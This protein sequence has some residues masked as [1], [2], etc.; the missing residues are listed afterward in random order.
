MATKNDP[1]AECIRQ[2]LDY[3]PK[4]GIFVWKRRSPN[5][6]KDG[7]HS[8]E[9]KCAVW[10]TKFAGK[11]AGTINNKGYGSIVIRGIAMAAHRLA[12]LYVNDIYPNDQID[13]IDGNRSNNKI[14]NLRE[15]VNG[16]NRN[17]AKLQK[18]NT[19]GDKNVHYCKSAKKWL[20]RFNINE[21]K[22]TVFRSRD[23]ELSALVAS[24]WRDYL[25]GEFARHK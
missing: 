9:H 10:N 24:E 20:V 14:S 2:I 1:T 8:R 15:A 4:T 23:L 21:K 17:N 11:N 22:I 7:G 16:Q 5:V 12:F 25:H 19:S 3:N 18:N 13:H 6:F